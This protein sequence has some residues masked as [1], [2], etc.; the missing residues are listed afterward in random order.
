MRKGRAA[1]VLQRTQQ[2][3]GID[4]IARTIQI[5][6]AIIAANIVSIRC[7]GA[8]VVEDVFARRAGVEDCIRYF[9]KAE[10][11]ADA[12]ANVSRVPAECTVGNRQVAGVGDTAAGAKALKCIP[13]SCVAADSAITYCQSPF[14]VDAAAI[15]RIIVPA[16]TSRSISSDGAAGDCECAKI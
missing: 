11:V 3:I 10:L 15:A 7:D 2:R 9:Q 6:P 1:I 13:R 16:E 8:G 12:S 4:L 5:A 14:V